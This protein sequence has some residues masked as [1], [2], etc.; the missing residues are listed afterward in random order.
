MLFQH[1]L[2][3]KLSYKAVVNEIIK[4]FPNWLMNIALLLQTS[5]VG[6]A[7][8][9]SIEDCPAILRSDVEKLYEDIL[10]Q[11]DSPEPFN[12]FLKMYDIRA[13]NSSVRVLY[14]LK[15]GSTYSPDEQISEILQ[16]NNEILSVSE[17]IELKEIVS[18]LKI[19]MGVPLITGSLKLGVDMVI[20]FGYV[21]TNMNV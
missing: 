21:M 19:T 14:A 3:K 8:Y 13:I 9:E 2:D 18:K 10:E 5:N 4:E 1:I 7:I 17:E 16:K 20:F 11:P 6:S 12:D 15:E